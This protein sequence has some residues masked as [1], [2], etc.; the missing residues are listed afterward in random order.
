MLS[1]GLKIIENQ[2]AETSFVAFS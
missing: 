1:S 2:N